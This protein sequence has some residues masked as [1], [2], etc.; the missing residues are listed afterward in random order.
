MSSDF[1]TS[2]GMNRIAAGTLDFVHRFESW[3]LSSSGNRNSSAFSGKC[4][5]SG[6]A[7][8]GTPTRDD[9]NLVGKTLHTVSSERHYY[10]CE[11]QNG[12][13]HIHA[14]QNLPFHPI[15]FASLEIGKHFPVI[16]FRDWCRKSFLWKYLAVSHL[17]CHF[18]PPHSV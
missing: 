14:S 2:V 15:R 8:S 7:D 10:P 9:R 11:F 17:E 16:G 12:M 5:R 13:R 18:W 1:E 4:D 6:F 3:L